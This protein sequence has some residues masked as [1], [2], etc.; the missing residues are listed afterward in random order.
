M[1]APVLQW[2]VFI[3]D[4]A[5]IVAGLMLFVHIYLAIIHPMMN[6]AWA[7]MTGGKISAEYAKKHHAKW[8]EE[9]SKG[10]D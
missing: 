5:F 2:M 7:A 8:Y 6:E 4:I 10:K 9:V 3:H 1:S